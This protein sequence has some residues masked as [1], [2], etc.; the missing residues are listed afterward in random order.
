MDASN[1]PYN[2]DRVFRLALTAAGFFIVFYLIYFLRDVLFPFAVALV[3][4]Y[5]L[6]P[7]AT[8]IQAKT[9]KR[10]LAV[11]LTVLGLVVACLGL[12]GFVVPRVIFEVTDFSHNIQTVYEKDPTLGGLLT[13]LPED[14]K[15]AV[16]SIVKEAAESVD[17]TMIIDAA[18]NALPRFWGVLAGALNTLLSLMTLMVILLY[19]VFL[20]L[21]FQSFQ[22]TW[23]DY[24]PPPYREPFIEFLE[25]FSDAMSKY[26]R[27]QAVV[28][29]CVG[30]L[31]AIGLS[32]LGIRLAVLLGLT[33]GLMNMVP[34]L[35]IIGL[36]PAVLLAVLRGV[37]TGTSP[38]LMLIGVLVIFGVVQLIQ[39]AFL[40]PRIIGKTTGL[41]PA[42]ILLAITV[43]GKLLGPLG[44]I[45]AIPLTCLGFAYYRRMLLNWRQTSST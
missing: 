36:F 18:R 33:I 19:V 16:E 3:L 25:E 21:D 10:S 43:W 39:D 32:L 2:F 15:K 26:F 29:F 24:L 22:A 5:L 45:L 1:R 4:A 44:L 40:T 17:Q 42:V 38:L 41:R 20:L 11:I 37:E 34:Y 9:G 12:V 8:A 31:F 14:L 27:G 13:P 28:A 7:I 6:N 35:Q 30:I 23:K